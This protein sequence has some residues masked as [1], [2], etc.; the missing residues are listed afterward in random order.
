MGGGGT[1]RQCTKGVPPLDQG[2]PPRLRG[3]LS[4]PMGTPS[5]PIGYAPLDKGVPSHLNQGV[6]SGPMGYPCQHATWWLDLELGVTP[7]VVTLGGSIR[8]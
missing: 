4:K 8:K 5:G 3:T 7:T 2:V 6:P 1:P